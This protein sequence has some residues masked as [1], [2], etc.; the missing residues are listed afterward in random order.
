MD[1]KLNVRVVTTPSRYM[2]EDYL[3]ILRFCKEQKFPL[4]FGEMILNPSR[5]DPMKDDYYLSMDEI[6]EFSIRREELY[7]KLV[8]QDS[9][10]E[11]CGLIMQEPQRGLTCN[12]GASLTSVTWDGIMYP[13][14]NVMVGGGASLREMSY[15]E[16][17][18]HT[19][20]VVNEVILGAECVGCPYDKACPKCPALRLTGLQTGHCNPEVCK[21]TR[22]LVAEG[23]KKLDAPVETNC[24]E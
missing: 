5:D 12:A 7:R 20:A 3:R 8:P 17:W 4:A 24:Q 14:P 21:L 2:G 16:A 9:T 18:K 1:A 10:P 13:C 23:V 22:R 15:A 6:A 19:V 11:P